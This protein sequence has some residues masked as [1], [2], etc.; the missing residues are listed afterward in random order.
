MFF[1]LPFQCL[2]SE[3]STQQNSLK[4]ETFTTSV[5]KDNKSVSINFVVAMLDFIAH[6]VT[7][8]QRFHSFCQSHFKHKNKPQTGFFPNKQF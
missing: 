7:N 3:Y 8:N 6:P 1:P 2:R 5:V 4:Q